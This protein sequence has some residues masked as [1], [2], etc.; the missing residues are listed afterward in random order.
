MVYLVCAFAVLV[1]LAMTAAAIAVGYYLGI[2]AGWAV[3]AVEFAILCVV[4]AFS[5][6]WAVR[7]GTGVGE[8]E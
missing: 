3:A 4:C 2:A 6:R 1:V 8:G 7:L 5:I